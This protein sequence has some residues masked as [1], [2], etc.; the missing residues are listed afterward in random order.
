MFF[1]GLVIMHTIV[2]TNSIHMEWDKQKNEAN[3]RAHG[4][5]FND[6]SGI[7]NE[8][9]LIKMDSRKDYGEKRWIGLGLLDGIV[10]VIVYTMR[11]YVLRIISVRKANRNER[12]IYQKSIEK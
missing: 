6:V 7:F 10:L 11:N 3:I 9:I 12:K 5:D 2:Y 4:I 8:H 1:D